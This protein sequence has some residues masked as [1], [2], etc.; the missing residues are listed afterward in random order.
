MGVVEV[1]DPESPKEETNS[2]SEES[3]SEEEIEQ[4]S[5]IGPGNPCMTLNSNLVVLKYEAPTKITSTRS[6][7]KRV[8]K[9]ISKKQKKSKNN[10]VCD[11][12]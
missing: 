4:E 10:Y 12:I 8:N 6:N 3:C 2:I 1:L 7:P 5:E 11:E 9:R